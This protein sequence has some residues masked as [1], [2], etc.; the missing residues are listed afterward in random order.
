VLTKNL[1]KYSFTLIELIIS[2]MIVGIAVTS[3]PMLLNT[4]SNNQE[5]NLKEKSFFNAYA[6]LTL[7]QTQEWDENNTKG[8]NYYKVL[9]S[10]GGDSELKCPRSGVVQLDND[11]G[12][13]CAS[14]DNKISS[15]RVDTGEDEDN[16]STFDD[17]D[18]FNNYSV[19]INDFNITA[20][21]SYMNDE[22]DYSVSNIYLNAENL[23]NSDSNI[24]LVELNITNKNTNEI[25]AVLKY[26]IS[27]IGM[28]KIESRNE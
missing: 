8:D 9:T 14:D 27:N 15:I 4:V 26:F 2:I 16:V 12:A 3:I 17:V 22:T 1:K 13:D 28:T 25:I 5:V 23:K 6:L 24:K 18:D 7:L 20:Y 10:D 19:I 11:S 21:I